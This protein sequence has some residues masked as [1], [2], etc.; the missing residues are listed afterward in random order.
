MLVVFEVG[1]GIVNCRILCSQRPHHSLCSSENFLPYQKA[2]RLKAVVLTICPIQK[3]PLYP[4]PLSSSQ[5]HRAHSHIPPFS[6]YRIVIPFSYFVQC[7]RQAINN[8]TGRVDLAWSIATHCGYQGVTQCHQA[9]WTRRRASRVF[10]MG[11]DRLKCL[12]DTAGRR[13]PEMSMLELSIDG[14]LGCRTLMRKLI[15]QTAIRDQPTRAEEAHIDGD[16][17][18]AKAC[19]SWRSG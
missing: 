5:C 4:Q 14:V 16:R 12:D 10:R 11:S 8:P 18:V 13:S 3:Q 2:S 15:V 7:G 1:C 17:R 9:R 6:K 19:G